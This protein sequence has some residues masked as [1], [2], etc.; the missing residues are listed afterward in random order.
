MEF[1]LT[2]EAA[3]SLNSTGLRELSF[4]VK[5]ADRPKFHSE[6][7][8]LNQYNRPRLIPT[9][10]TY[11]SINFNFYDT[12]T[13]VAII[14]LNGVLNAQFKDFGGKNDS[15]WGWDVLNADSTSNWGVKLKET[16]TNYPIEEISVFSFYGNKYDQFTLMNP[17]IESADLSQGDHGNSEMNEI[18]ITVKPEGVLFKAIGQQITSSISSKFGIPYANG[19]TG[20]FPISGAIP[21]GGQVPS[22]G[23][24]FL[25]A[26]TQNLV[27]TIA[28][29]AIIPAFSA[30]NAG[31]NGNSM[32]GI[33]STNQPGLSSA[34]SG[35]PSY[36]PL[37]NLW[38]AVSGSSNNFVSSTPISDN[39]QPISW[40][41]AT[42]DLGTGTGKI[43]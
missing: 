23:N 2:P 17:R 22:G 12:P 10:I 43:Y 15:S 33:S 18:S 38:N 32:L 5:S 34:I 26:L 9:K 20:N 28:T 40:N 39:N 30:I 25:N 35:T 14:F 31:L 29:S 6:I 4:R 36:S 19:T 37:N 24:S 1:I 21:S 11:G 42:A 8:T 27:P 16:S 13:A 3:Q 7:Q 41:G